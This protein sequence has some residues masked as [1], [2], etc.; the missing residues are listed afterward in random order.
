MKNLTER[1]SR[2]EMQDIIQYALENGEFIDPNDESAIRTMANIYYIKAFLR[3]IDADE[4][5]K[6][7]QE[8]NFGIYRDGIFD[9][10][11]FDANEEYK[12][13]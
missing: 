5:Y 2:N 7:N 11:E 6:E 12:E 1:I 4:E 3:K 13:D 10:G 8:N 9:Y